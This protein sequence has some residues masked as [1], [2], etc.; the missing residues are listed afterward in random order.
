MSS[1]GGHRR[2]KL[3]PGIPPLPRSRCYRFTDVPT[4]PARHAALSSSAR[5]AS[6]VLT[7]AQP[8][9]VSPCE[10]WN[11]S[12][13]GALAGARRQRDGEGDCSRP[14]LAGHA[15]TRRICF[16]YGACRRREDQPVL[17]L[18]RLAAYAASSSPS[19][20]DSRW[21]ASIWTAASDP[22]ESIS[23]GL[24]CTSK[25]FHT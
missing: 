24:G 7:P 10:R 15:R 11:F 19:R 5:S 20:G 3:Y 9:T 23:I 16:H 21:A 17:R 22:A 18:P 8:S 25:L 14:P 2:T 6:L 1:L 12:T 4:P 13:V